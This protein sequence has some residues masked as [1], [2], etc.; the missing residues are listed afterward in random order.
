MAYDVNFLVLDGDDPDSWAPFNQPLSNLMQSLINRNVTVFSF[1]RPERILNF[2]PIFVPRAEWERYDQMD[3]VA[4][5]IVDGNALADPTVAEKVKNLL[6][7]VVMNWKA[8]DA[9]LCKGIGYVWIWIVVQKGRA[10]EVRRKWGGEFA[11]VINSYDADLFVRVDSVWTEEIFEHSI[12]T[13][14]ENAARDGSR[15][16]AF[17]NGR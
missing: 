7:N 15:R 8:S 11:E 2:E 17:K 14:L 3:Q 13:Y 12:P 16:G 5:L 4:G 9:A 1:G 10:D 6:R